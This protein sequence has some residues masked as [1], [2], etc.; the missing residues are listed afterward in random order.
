MR[1]REPTPLTRLLRALAF[2]VAMVLL[3]D[4]RVLSLWA[5]SLKDLRARA[6]FTGIVGPLTRLTRVHGL[7]RAEAGMNGVFKIALSGSSDGSSVRIGR[8]PTARNGVAQGIPAAQG[9]SAL[10]Q[11]SAAQTE[12]VAIEVPSPKPEPS[13]KPDGTVEISDSVFY[14]DYYRSFSFSARTAAAEATEAAETVHQAMPQNLLFI[15]DS[16]LGSMAGSLKR[17]APKHPD[18]SIQLEYGISSALVQSVYCDW[19]KRLERLL[20]ESDYDCVVIFLGANDGIGIHVNGV[21]L[22]FDS[23]AWREEYQGRVRKLLKAIDGKAKRIYWL[24]TPPMRKQ[25]YGD[26]M[27][28]INELVAQV[29]AEFPNAAYLDLFP[30][31]GDSSGRY[32]AA[33]NFDGELKTVRAEDG[34]HFSQAGAQLLTDFVFGRLGR[35]SSA[36]EDRGTADRPSPEGLSW[37]SGPAPGP[38]P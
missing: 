8:S 18:Y 21:D 27:K 26:K 11:S 9:E 3:F 4:G 2:V 24:G 33:M 29:C 10:P 31:L 20:S 22:A 35:D 28:R 25:T 15:G 1:R 7:E 16:L 23:E 17:S 14:P 34:I 37:V 38:S 30:L 5:D 32:Q 19:Q 36:G 12:A 6:L 13:S